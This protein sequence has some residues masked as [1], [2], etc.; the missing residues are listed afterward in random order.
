MQRAVRALLKNEG[1]T[2][3]WSRMTPI[4]RMYS[5]LPTEQEVTD[6]WDQCEDRFPACQ[7]LPPEL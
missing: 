7:I 4:Q 2:K 1:D 5:D 3:G 6:N